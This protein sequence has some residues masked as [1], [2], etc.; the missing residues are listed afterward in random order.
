MT[1]ICSEEM[2]WMGRHFSVSRAYCGRTASHSPDAFFSTS[3]HSRPPRN[4]NPSRRMLATV[5]SLEALMTYSF[6]QISQYLRCPRQYRYR[7]LDG[8][9]EKKDKASMIFGRCFENALSVYFAREDPTAAFFQEWRKHQHGS[10]TYAKN[11]SWD[12]LYH[13][14][15]HLLER[16]G[17]NDRVQIPRSKQNLQVKLPRSLPCGGDFVSYIG[18]PSTSPMAS[19][20]TGAIFSRPTAGGLGG[21]IHSTIRFTEGR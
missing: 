2:R 18:I 14:G 21:R 15:I 10:L 6:T 4:G 9:R 19:Y 8:W 1:P 20:P 3:M 12:R 13:Q 11:D 17:Q 5:L 16:F 7:Y